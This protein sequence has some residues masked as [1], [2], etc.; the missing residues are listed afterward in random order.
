MRAEKSLIRR[1]V[2]VP[3]GEGADDTGGMSI[4]PHLVIDPVQPRA[5]SR[6]MRDIANEPQSVR[7]WQQGADARLAAIVVAGDDG[8]VGEDP[9]DIH[10]P[11]RIAFP[12]LSGSEGANQ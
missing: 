7:P 8:N 11:V 6:N 9:A 4:Q 10:R 12:F 3:V 2:N 5:L 1:I